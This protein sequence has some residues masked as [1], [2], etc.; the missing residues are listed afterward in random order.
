MKRIGMLVVVF[1]IGLA[2][3]FCYAQEETVAEQTEADK[4]FQEGY[5]LNNRAKY[6]EAIETLT[7][8]IDADPNHLRANVYLGV[9]LM[10]KEDY[11]AAIAQLKKALSLDEKYPLTNYALA[12]SY[13]RKDPP[14]IAEARTYVEIAKQNGYHV[15]PW[16]FDYLK[17]LESGNLPPKE[18]AVPEAEKTE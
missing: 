1:I 15:P 14:E 10:G 17:R 11:D 4:L 5:D 13:G 8:A 9:A 3:V 12:V 7:K 6:D 16:F 18:G 2:A